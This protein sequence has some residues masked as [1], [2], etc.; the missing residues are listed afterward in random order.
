MRNFLRL[1]F[2]ITIFTL[3]AACGGGG[4]GGGDDNPTFSDGS[5]NSDNVHPIAVNG[6]SQGIPNLAYT[7]VIVCVPGTTQCQ[8]I[9]NIIV[10][11]GSVGLRLV[12]SALSLSLPAQAAA[13]NNALFNCARFADTSHAW[14]RVRR[15]DI[16]LGSN[17][18]SNVP[19]Q[20]I[21]DVGAN[22]E[23]VSC[24]GGDS[25]DNL[26]TV[27]NMGGNGIL[28]VGYFRED[29]GD[30]CTTI[31][32]NNPRYYSCS[33]GGCAPSLAALNTQ[34]QNPVALFSSDNNGVIIQLPAISNNGEASV[35]GSMIF[36]IG[37][38]SNN[39]LGNATIYTTDNGYISSRYNNVDYDES[40]I[41]SGSNGLF[42]PD[43]IPR[44]TNS[45][46]FYCPTSTLQLS[47]TIRGDN[48]NSTTIPFSVV[49]AES[50]NGNLNA[51]NNL[52][53]YFAGAFDWGMPF[54]FGRKVYTGF[55]TDT[56]EPYVAF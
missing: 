35:S 31:L 56:Q 55:D 23:P 53:G 44:C 48:N 52:G 34:L 3:I 51:F 7:S 12:S 49:N 22:S 13:N 21:G 17:T 1:F 11:T 25:N 43:S 47:A 29:C 4:G 39:S 32:S 50:L 16:K 46:G 20:T 42:F 40:F 10:D 9:N 36:G 2:P 33:T 15:A 24:G 8:T 41:D 26:S 19:V 6:G 30:Y 45:D 38:R 54:F 18:A 37:T 14:G 28:G 5:T 27:A